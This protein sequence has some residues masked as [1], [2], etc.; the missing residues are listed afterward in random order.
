MKIAVISDLHTGSATIAKDFCVGDSA[1]AVKEGYMDDLRTLTQSESLDI[2]YLIVAGDITNRSKYEEFELAAERI[3]ECASILNVDMD[4]IFFVPGN[5]DCN[6]KDEEESIIAGDDGEKTIKRKYQQI[7]NQGFFRDIMSRSS[8][9]CFY[10]EPYFTFWE[11]EKINVFGVNSS[12]FDQ[13]DKKPHHGSIR[14]SDIKKLEEI[15]VTKNIENSDKL[16][17][18]V[19]HHHPIQHHDLPFEQADLSILQNSSQLMELM[20]KYNFNFVI[21]GHKHIPRVE[22]HMDSYQHPVNILCAGSFSAYLDERFFQGVP[23]SIHVIEIDSICNTHRVPQGKVKSWY[24]YSG[25]GWIVDEPVNSAPHIEYF[26]NYLSKVELTNKLTEIINVG[27]SLNGHISWLD[28]CEK[29]ISFK[30]TPRRLLNHVIKQLSK[31]LGFKIYIDDD[32]DDT[33]ILMKQKE[34]A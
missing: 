23:N 6:W 8:H 19:I 22:Q 4:K 16:N 34:I 15:I 14:R 7:E 1:S 24:H 32:S 33:F 20:T 21:H 9:G 18:L 12:V 17:L 13:F 30:Y 31:S 11:D 29:E 2:D 10:K 25:H 3:K 27:L 26:G 28:I 5:H